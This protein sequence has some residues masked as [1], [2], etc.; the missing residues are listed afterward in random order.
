VVA[1]DADLAIN[2][3]ANLSSVKAGKTLTYTLTVHNAGPA[4]ASGLLPRPEL[5]RSIG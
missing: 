1:A 4:P 5:A 2:K 3:S